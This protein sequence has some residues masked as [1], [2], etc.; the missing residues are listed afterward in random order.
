MNATR[1]LRLRDGAVLDVRPIEPGDVPRLERMFDRLSPET[2]YRR[3]FSPVHRPPPRTL[4]RL[5]NVDHDSREALVALHGD[6]IVAVAR[7]DARRGS[8]AAEI[9]VTVEDAWQHRGL[10]LRLA[11]R[12]AAL[13]LDH[14]FD[15]FLATMLP[16]NRPALGL[17]RKLSPTAAVRF[18]GGSYEAIA[19][20][21]RA[22]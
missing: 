8:H 15:Q 16:D 14:G 22:S 10:G 1:E 2:V 7:Y 5:A 6:E 13:A 19:P 12:L 9:A 17:L 18:D 3:F 20:L 21:D 11:R 4:E